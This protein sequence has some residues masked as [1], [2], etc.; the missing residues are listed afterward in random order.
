MKKRGGGTG[1]KLP[2]LKKIILE[3]YWRRTKIAEADSDGTV[4]WLSKIDPTLNSQ[5]DVGN[6]VPSDIQQDPASLPSRSLPAPWV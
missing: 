4:T 6:M 1:K 3:I 2:L 5:S